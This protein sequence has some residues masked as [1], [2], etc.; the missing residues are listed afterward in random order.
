MADYVTYHRPKGIKH[1]VDA[2]ESGSGVA[3]I[4]FVNDTNTDDLIF[5]AKV[6]TSANVV[7]T[8][9]LDID[10]NVASGLIVVTNGT[11][12]LATNDIVEI[13]GMFYV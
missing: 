12:N 10:Y 8:V 13:I 1:V 11:V 6:T 4:P 2:G 7:K 9:G 5:S 3:L